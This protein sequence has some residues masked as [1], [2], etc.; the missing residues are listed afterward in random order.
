MYLPQHL[1]EDDMVEAG[2]IGLIDAA[3]K[4]DRT[5]QVK[6]KTY[7]IPRIR[8]AMLDE[9]RAQDWIPRSARKKAQT[10]DR[11]YNSLHDRWDRDPTTDEMAEELGVTP[12]EVTKLLSDV[13]FASLISLE[14][15]QAG[16]QDEGASALSIVDSLENP[17]SI[18]PAEAYE[19]GEQKGLL[20]DAIAG[21]PEQERLVITL[22]YFE[23][24]L[25]KEIG[26]IMGVSESRISQLHSKAVFTLRAKMKRTLVAAA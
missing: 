12:K 15:A 5:R 13:R 19:R 10:L 21:L 2:T 9:L 14:A 17:D 7:A 26:E 4:F 16:S 18:N 1:D 22:Y 6:F 11:A 20:A 24:L 8:G 3:E 23:D 25:L